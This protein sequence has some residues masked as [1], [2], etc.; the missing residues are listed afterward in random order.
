MKNK[1]SHSF[2]QLEW[3]YR[4]INVGYKQYCDCCQINMLGLVMPVGLVLLLFFL[5]VFHNDLESTGEL[6]LEVCYWNWNFCVRRNE[7][8]L[9]TCVQVTW[10]IQFLLAVYKSS[11]L[12]VKVVVAYV[13][14]H[15]LSYQEIGGS[16]FWAL[17]ILPIKFCTV[18]KIT[19]FKSK[20][21]EDG[22]NVQGWAGDSLA[23]HSFSWMLIS[24]FFNLLV[25]LTF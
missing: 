19:F 25:R 12:R 22:Q 20:I 9:I 14:S 13:F 15:A 3:R 16:G 5:N 6:Y 11:L 21:D 1:P 18:T 10:S 7:S 24:S 23:E 8:S 2:V 17:Q 4:S